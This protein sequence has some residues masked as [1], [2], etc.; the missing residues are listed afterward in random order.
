MLALGV[1]VA[2][3][4]A[5]GVEQQ[6]RRMRRQHIRVR[7]Q[8]VHAD[9]EEGDAA[10][11]RL[12]PSKGIAYVEGG[13]KQLDIVLKHGVR[14]TRRHDHA[15]RGAVRVNHALHPGQERRLLPPPDAAPAVR[16]ARLH[17]SRL[18]DEDGRH[19]LR[20]AEAAAPHLSGSPLEARIGG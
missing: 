18:L 20:T 17:E 4:L 12:A 10:A 19:A 11:L 8:V 15:P 16:T 13:A 6:R 7:E 5:R 14:A 3:A 2:E 9:A 1:P